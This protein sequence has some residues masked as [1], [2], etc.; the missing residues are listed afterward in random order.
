VVSSR[1]AG[2]FV[3]SQHFFFA[4]QHSQT[5]GFTRFALDGMVAI[6]SRRVFSFHVVVR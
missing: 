6:Q 3:A 1:V 4:L 5:L 2:G